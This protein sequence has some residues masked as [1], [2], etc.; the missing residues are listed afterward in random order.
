MAR[1]SRFTW[2]MARS[3]GFLPYGMVTLLQLL[4]TMSAVAF[5]CSNPSLCG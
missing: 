4:Q 1:L 5:W 2:T 3:V